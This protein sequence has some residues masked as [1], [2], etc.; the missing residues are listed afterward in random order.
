[1]SRFSE[2]AEQLLDSTKGQERHLAIG[3]RNGKPDNPGGDAAWQGLVMQACSH[4]RRSALHRA[5]KR[6]VAPHR[7]NGCRCVALYPHARSAHVQRR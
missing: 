7:Y 5:Q 4:W 1:M 2:A 3:T 6:A